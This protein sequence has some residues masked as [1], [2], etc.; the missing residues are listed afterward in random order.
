MSK[1]TSKKRV[2]EQVADSGFDLVERLR[3]QEQEL[4]RMI[5]A[6]DKQ[7]EIL[8]LYY[9]TF[10]EMKQQ[11]QRK[12]LMGYIH[13]RDNMLKDVERIAEGECVDE[14][15]LRLLTT[16]IEELDELLEDNGVEILHCCENDEY[17]PE[18][19]K[20]LER[21]DIKQAELDNKVIRVFGCGYR[22]N[23]I[24]LKKA[25]V[26]VGVYDQPV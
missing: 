1:G 10:Q 5:E 20:P 2:G 7:Q 4:R 8:R 26:A 6:F 16:Y 24:V 3:A 18:T 17:D 19:Q 21:V 12:Y 22:W 25:Y 15:T 11:N 9:K 14:N 13:M 23:E